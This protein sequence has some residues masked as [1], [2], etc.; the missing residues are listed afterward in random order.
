[1][2]IVSLLPSATE[3]VFALGRGAHLVGRSE[4][5]DYPTEARDRPVVM[6]ARAHDQGRSSKDIDERVRAS[7]DDPNGL[8]ELDLG[9]LRSLAPDVI[10]TQDLCRVCSV[11]DDQVR[12]ACRASGVDPTIVS[13]SPTRLAEV[14]GGILEIGRAVGAEREAADWVARA[15]AQS[16]PPIERNE[17]LPSVAVVE[18]L[19]PPILAGLWVP[20]MID[21]AGGSPWKVRA[22]A[23]GARIRWEQLGDPAPDLIVLSPCSFSVERTRTETRAGGLRDQIDGLRPRLGIWIT[24]EAYFSRP[25]PRLLGGTALLRALLTGKQPPDPSTCERYQAGRIGPP[26]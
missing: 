13:V 11:T 18:W 23:P 22:G 17:R 14:W 8:Y 26:R 6:R 15:D 7:R 12:E 5:C 19:D 20:D 4:E 16:R 1:M 25:G 21:A 9:L 10:L 3:T 2:R 24:D